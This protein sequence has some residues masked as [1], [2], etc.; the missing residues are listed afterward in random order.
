MKEYPDNTIEEVPVELRKPSWWPKTKDEERTKKTV[1]QIR[2]LL[3][4][5]N[6]ENAL[7]IFNEMHPVDCGD[8]LLELNKE[9]QQEILI[10]ASLEKVARI[11]EHMETTE[12]AGVAEKMKSSALSEVLDETRPD[13]AADILKQLSKEQSMEILEAMEEAADVIPLLK[14][15]DDTAGGL[16]TP[17]YPKVEG[18]LTASSA[19]GQLRLRWPEA[20]NF[21]SILVVDAESRLV[22]SI[23]VTRLALAKPTTAVQDIMELE[24]IAVTV[25]KDQEECIRLIERYDLTQLPVV[26][27]E[28]RL[29]GVVLGEDVVDVVEEEATEDMYKI[30]AISGER[31]FG[32][33]RNSVRSRLPWLYINLATAFLAAAV[34]SLFESTITKVVA[35]A[36]FLPVVAGQGGIGGTQ[37]LTL[38]VRSMALGEVSGRSG[39][40]LLLREVTLGLI[41]GLLL[42]IVVGFL[43]YLWKRDFMLGVVLSIAMVSNMLVAGLAGAGIPLLLRRLGMDPAVSSAVFVTTFT[44]VIGF[45][46][47]LGLAS[48]FIGYLL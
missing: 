11:L 42:G 41:H 47:F 43:A 38:V 45:M 30:A 39:V 21:S 46:L 36:V 3:E 13:V 7:A 2:K 22:G 17:E 9:R 12:A 27:G 29:V 28:N 31:V 16:M 48:M 10:Y 18:R 4:E 33:L 15:D 37:T 44:D 25:E 34:I 20:D 23:G 40:R 8:V 5:G 14:Y 24:V 6:R 26:D 19:V 1:R 32:P 35:L